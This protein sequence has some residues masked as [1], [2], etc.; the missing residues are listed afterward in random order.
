M[1][2]DGTLPRLSPRLG[3]LSRSN[4]E[5]ILGARSRDRTDI[6]TGVAITSSIHPEQNTHVEVC[7]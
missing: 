1:R 3:E 7:R 6:A 5:A 2:R 4:S